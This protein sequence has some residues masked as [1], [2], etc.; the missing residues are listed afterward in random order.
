MQKCYLK[1]KMMC[2]N[3]RSQSVRVM[4]G[5]TLFFRCPISSKVIHKAP[6][7]GRKTLDCNKTSNNINKCDKP[8][9]STVKLLKNQKSINNITCKN[10]FI[11][12][13]K[14]IDNK[15]ISIYYPCKYCGELLS[16]YQKHIIEQKSSPATNIDSENE[17]YI[18]NEEEFKVKM[19]V[20]YQC[21][22]CGKS[23]K[24]KNS[25]KSHQRTHKMKNSCHLCG[26]LFARNSGLS[27][28]MKCVHLGIKDYSCDI[29]GLSFAE[30]STM[31]DHRKTHTGENPY[32][33]HECDKV[34]T[35]KGGLSR[36][37]KNIHLGIKEYNC[38]FCG[39]TFAFK[40]G[41][42]DHRRIHTGEKP[43]ICDICGKSF[44]TNASLYIHSKTHTDEFP[45]SCNYCQH[46]FRWKH[47][48]VDHLRIHTGEKKFICDV[49]GK[50]FRVKND[51][52][53]H[54]R[55]EYGCQAL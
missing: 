31:E 5:D 16:Q 49:C 41:L 44:K 4:M 34:F 40:S 12:K 15:I 32:F 39:L 36:H 20:L 24:L 53:R 33:C 26:K 2:N 22:E 11:D 45:H 29:C 35:R 9:Q 25:Y 38:D 27:R 3:N 42:E 8:G 52:T 50:Q 7:F 14:H 54:K 43:Y 55:K 21:E 10:I 6:I 13:N 46:Q 30:K 37:T 19:N 47:K 1:C 17:Y 23:F 18:F 28:H 51:L 48:L